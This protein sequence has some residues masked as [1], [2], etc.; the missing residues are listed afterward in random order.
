VG[1]IAMMRGSKAST[2][3]LAYDP[4]LDEERRRK[5]VMTTTDILSM[6]DMLE[7]P[8]IPRRAVEVVLDLMT[9][10]RRD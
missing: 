10:F 6:P 3:R 5:Q 2:S 1:E 7:L 4:E 8:I 9:V